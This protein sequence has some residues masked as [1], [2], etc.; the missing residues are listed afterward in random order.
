MTVQD[1]SILPV[2]AWFSKR[3]TMTYW[4]HDNQWEVNGKDTVMTLGAAAKVMLTVTD[5]TKKGYDMN[6]LSLNLFPTTKSNRKPRILSDRQR[7][8]SMMPQ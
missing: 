7:I 1:D 2:I 6:I 8:F 3:D 5:S 4:I